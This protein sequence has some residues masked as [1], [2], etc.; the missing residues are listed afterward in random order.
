MDLKDAS[1]MTEASG[2]MNDPDTS[3]SMSPT[4]VFSEKASQE[5]LLRTTD[6]LRKVTLAAPLSSL[7][8]A[9]LAGILVARRR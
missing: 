6:L 2:V 3:E 8:V 4:S 7:F 1:A 9:F 5:A